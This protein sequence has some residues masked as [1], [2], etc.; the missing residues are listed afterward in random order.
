M[1][2]EGWIG[3]AVES[4]RPV[5]GA[6]GIIPAVV[7]VLLF[8]LTAALYWPATAYNFVSLDDPNYVFDNRQVLRRADLGRA[9][10]GRSPRSTPRTGT[11]SPGC[12]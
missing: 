7:S 10:A 8:L 11:R 12:R 1:S 5:P 6:G 3:G 9:C 2:S 4:A